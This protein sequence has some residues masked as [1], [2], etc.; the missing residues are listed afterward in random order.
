MT[1][2]WS[3]K[4]FI[5]GFIYSA[6]V[7]VL[8]YAIKKYTNVDIS[9]PWQPLSVLGIAVAFYLGFKNNASYDRI[10][11]A[12]K[13]W[14]GI[15]NNSRT[16]GAAVVAFVQGENDTEIKKRILY[17]HIAWLTALRYQLRL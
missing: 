2:N 15:V 3:K 5:Y 14:G 16:Y 10:W 8:A 6:L 11:E 17:R 12:R 7:G 9:V 13:I 1:F 4:P